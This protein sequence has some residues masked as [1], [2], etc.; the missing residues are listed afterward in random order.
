MFQYFVCHLKFNFFLL[1]NRFTFSL[2]HFHILKW[3][4]WDVRKNC[5]NM[6]FRITIIASFLKMQCAFWQRG[7]P[8]GLFWSYRGRDNMHNCV[9]N[10]MLK[11]TWLLTALLSGLINFF[12][13]ELQEVHAFTSHLNLLSWRSQ[14]QI[15]WGFTVNFFGH[16]TFD[17]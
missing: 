13:F 11:Y 8:L 6:Y 17:R 16:R 9:N 4:N 14:V 1:L 5:R 3:L 7:W 2:F 10:K 12:K 15:F